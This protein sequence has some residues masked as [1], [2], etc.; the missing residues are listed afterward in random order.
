MEE[1]SNL[2]N[3]LTP[4]QEDLPNSS[5]DFGMNEDEIKN[6][7]LKSA[8]GRIKYYFSAVEPA[9][10]K[11]FSAILYWTMKIIKSVVGSAFRMILGKEV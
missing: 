9:I 2:N 8:W 4:V 5:S 10:I 11:V 7:K 3:N 1:Q 6:Y